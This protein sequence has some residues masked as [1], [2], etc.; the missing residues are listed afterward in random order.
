MIKYILK[1]T[2]INANQYVSETKKLFFL[3]RPFDISSVEVPQE[4]E[5]NRRYNSSSIAGHLGINQENSDHLLNKQIE[6]GTQTEKR[7]EFCQT[8]PYTPQEIIAKHENPEILAL[9]HFKWGV[10]L[11]PTIEELMYIEE[12]R[13]KR[14]FEASLPPLSDEFSFNIRRKIMEHQEIHEWQKRE[15][16]IKKTQ[17]KKLNLL[18]HMLIE[19]EKT[20]EENNYFRAETVKN[21]LN[22]QKNILIAK[23]QARKIKAIRKLSQIEKKFQSLKMQTSIIDKYQNFGSEIYA[24]IMR[25]GFSLERFSDRFKS[26][27][28]SLTNFERYKELIASIDP[29]HFNVNISLDEMNALTQRKY[30]K[31][32]KHNLL[33]LKK[34]QDSFTSKVATNR[35]QNLGDIYDL[36]IQNVVPRPDTPYYEERPELAN[37]PHQ[38]VNLDR[39]NIKPQEER[40]AFE[41]AKHKLAALIQR[42]LRGRA[43]QNI[44][45]E[46]KEKRLALID[47][48]LI[49]SN[50]ETKSV[51]EEDKIVAK[52]R[53][54]EKNIAELKHFEGKIISH[55]L[56]MLNKELLK[57]VEAE[58]LKEFV[59]TAEQERQ[60]REIEETGKRQAKTILKNR[61]E[62]LYTDM[63]NVHKET[64]FE[65]LD[66]VFDFSTDFLAQNEACK[67]TEI[68]ERKFTNYVEKNNENY[69]VLIKDFLQLF[70]VP[71]I[72]RQKLQNKI[73]ESQKRNGAQ[74]T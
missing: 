50:T 14:A 53:E 61:E 38:E 49:V 17:S 26:N 64:I 37:Y 13:E 59:G 42:L 11:P 4:D 29:I 46:G 12:Q 15:N 34:A 60:K 74:N 40:I 54:N 22:V 28:E 48:L 44:M 16:E 68:K 39:Q 43:I 41:D 7:E 6:F 70:L 66:N 31:L 57:V 23:I 72:D 65:L 24:N 73:K 47:E 67:L 2:Q 30:L 21:S 9:K 35:N 27:L 55:T 18:Q 20:I 25:N 8:D 45:F 36:N 19:R 32:E 1:D 52:I 63:I 33:Q 51:F 69:E 58:K 62:K 5:N 3:A 56:E 71:N 10:H